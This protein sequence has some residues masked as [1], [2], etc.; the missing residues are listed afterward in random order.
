MLQPI[1]SH[2]EPIFP[3]RDIPETIRYWQ[4]VP[5]FPNKWTWGEPPT[6]GGVSWQKAFH[7]IDDGGLQRLQQG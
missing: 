2:V 1:F 7:R 6:N 3:V 4:E 5:G